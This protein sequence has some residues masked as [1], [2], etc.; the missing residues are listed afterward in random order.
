[1]DRLTLAEV[2]RQG[3]CLDGVRRFCTRHDISFK[4]FIREGVSFERLEQIDDAQLKAVLKEAV[5]HGS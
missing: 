1:M 3:M 4:E 2:R 5:R